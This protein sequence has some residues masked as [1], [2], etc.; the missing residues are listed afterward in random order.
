MLAVFVVEF[1]SFMVHK[2]KE[3]GFGDT[4]FDCIWGLF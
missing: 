4:D 1:I 3:A 2:L